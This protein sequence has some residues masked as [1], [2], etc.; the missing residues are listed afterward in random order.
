[1]RI[2]IAANNFL[3]IVTSPRNVCGKTLLLPSIQTG[4]NERDHS[5][6][7]FP[8]NLMVLRQVQF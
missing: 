7:V 2:I 3:D 8:N 4:D 1:M 5:W 6:L